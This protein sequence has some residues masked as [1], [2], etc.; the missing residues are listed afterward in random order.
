MR[1]NPG[2][3]MTC[4]ASLAAPAVGTQHTNT[5]TVTGTPVLPDGTPALGDDGLPIGPPQATDTAYAVS[6]RTPLPATG[7]T[8]APLVAT[9]IGTLL[10]GVALLVGSRRRQS[11]RRD[12]V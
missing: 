8:V 5:V 3:V 4:T 7:L 11:T 1:L 9:G 6:V 10:L 2:D 12:E